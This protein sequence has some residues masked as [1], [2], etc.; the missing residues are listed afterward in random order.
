MGKPLTLSEYSNWLQALCVESLVIS[1]TAVQLA[2]RAEKIVSLREKISLR[3]HEKRQKAK[4]LDEQIAQITRDTQSVRE[5][6]ADAEAKHARLSEENES[7]KRELVEQEASAQQCSQN[8]PDLEERRKLLEQEKS[9]LAALKQS[10]AEALDCTN[11]WD[12]LPILLAPCDTNSKT[13]TST[14]WS[15]LMKK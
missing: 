13:T 3:V 11:V 15:K 7:L 2:E 12:V 14:N 4:Q 5:C 9:E 8:L 10:V 6:L 1:R